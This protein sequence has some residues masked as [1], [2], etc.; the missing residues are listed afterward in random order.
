MSFTTPPRPFD[1]TALTPRLAPLARTATRLHPRPGSPTVHDSSVGGP[2][3]WPAD[4]PWPHCEGPHDASLAE[5]TPRSAEDIRALRRVRA[6]SAERRL[7]DRRAPVRTPEE[8]EVWRRHGGGRPWFEGPVPMLPVAQLYARDVPL[9]ARPAGSDLLQ[10]L[11]CPCGHG[12]SEPRTAL[13]W[14]SAATVTE[15][16][17][18]PPE[19]PAIEKDGYLPRPCLLT[20]EQVT[21]YPSTMELDEELQDQLSDES[22]WEAAGAEWDDGEAEDP[23]DFYFRNLATAPGW[24]TGGWTFWSLTDPEPRDCP[25]CGTEEI[26]LLTI[27]SSEWDDGSVSWRPAEDPADPAQHLPGDPSEPTLVDIRGGY[28]LQLH[29]CPASPDHPHLQIME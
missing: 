15:V 4:E 26:P 29:V 27:A 24:K 6:A 20:P 12:V 25:T 21:E 7:R 9:P 16:L 2:L 17:D 11:W 23:Q 14:R 5:D 22:R 19:P 1:V 3:L 13:F 28:T 10:V 18:A 8:D